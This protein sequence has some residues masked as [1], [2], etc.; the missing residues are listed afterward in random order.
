[1]DKLVSPFGTAWPE[2]LNF[3][4]SWRRLDKGGVDDIASW[5]DG[6]AEPRLVVI[7][8]LAGVRPVRATTGYNEDYEALGTLH[9]LAN[10]RAIAVLVLHHTRKM[11]AEDPIDTV[12]GTHGLTGCA[13]T[14]LVLARSSRGTTLY[15]RGRDVEEAEHAVAFD[16]TTC[17]WSILGE[18]SEVHRSN[19]RSRII[20]AIKES[21]KEVLGPQEIAGIVGITDVNVR[22]LLAKMVESGELVKPN[23]GQYGL[24]EKR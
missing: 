20:S 18:A 15:V 9:R 22:Q 23:R 3:A 7:D 24:P 2:R 11:E 13:D 4:L 12:S 21:G 6:A 10:D 19:E 14:V 8:T 16:K 17:R 5:A 1:V